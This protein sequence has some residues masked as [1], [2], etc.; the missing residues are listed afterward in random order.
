MAISGQQTA[1]R[2]KTA[3]HRENVHESKIDKHFRDK[4]QC[5]ACK[6]WKEKLKLK[7]KLNLKNI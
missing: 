7:L 4:C 1:E 5:A 2:R 3:F 6:T